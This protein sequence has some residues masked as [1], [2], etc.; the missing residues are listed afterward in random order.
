MSSDMGSVRDPEII[1]F[2]NCK[3]TLRCIL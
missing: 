3:V 2:S 1:Y